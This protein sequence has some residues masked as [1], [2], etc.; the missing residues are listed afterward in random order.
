MRTSLVF[1]VCSLAL[2]PRLAHAACPGLFASAPA[3]AGSG[4]AI[5]VVNGTGDV[6]TCDL[7]VAGTNGGTI[8]AVSNSATTFEAWG[9]ASN[10][11]LFCAA[12]THD[13]ACSPNNDVYVNVLGTDYADDIEL[14]GDGRRLECTTTTV[15]GDGGGDTIT[16]S[17]ATTNVDNLY[18]EGDNDTIS[19]MAGDDYLSGGAGNDTCAGGDGDDVIDGDG[20]N[21]LLLGGAGEDV[22]DGGDGTDD[23]QGG[24]DIDTMDGGADDD[25]MCGGPADD[26]MDGGD[27]DD[28]VF[29]GAG[30]DTV[31]GGTTGTDACGNTGDYFAVTCDSYGVA[32]CPI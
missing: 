12:L 29:G 13:D 19:G 17:T 20:A 9:T 16:G 27:D 26:V 6:V 1:S 11:G 30:T 23:M 10:G 18:G 14:L 15:H 4:T 32:T 25:R 28:L 24:E 2:T 21:D 5:C 31:D 3:D 8:H 7:D 22:M